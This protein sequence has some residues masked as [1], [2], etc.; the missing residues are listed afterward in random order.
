MYINYKFHMW[1]HYFCSRATLHVH[2]KLV[3]HIIIFMVFM[4]NSFS[5]PKHVVSKPM[6][7]G[8]NLYFK[9]ED[10]FHILFSYISF[11]FHARFSLSFSDRFKLALFH[12]QNMFIG[13]DKRQSSPS[14]L[15]RK[16]PRN[17]EVSKRSSLHWHLVIACNVLSLTLCVSSPVQS[18]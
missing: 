17:K 10:T 5:T 6:V 2:V 1:N 9:H 15:L 16:L 14:K 13:R 12:H 11:P 8:I 4:N 18:M 3:W 7:S